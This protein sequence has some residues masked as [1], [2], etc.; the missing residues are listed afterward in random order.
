MVRPIR[1]H[2]RDEVVLPLN[3]NMGLVIPTPIK[4]GTSREKKFI[5]IV[6]TQVTLPKDLH[7]VAHIP[8][9]VERVAPL[10]WLWLLKDPEAST[11][12]DKPMV[13][14]RLVTE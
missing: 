14:L 11:R 9:E 6:P 5:L 2:A 12:R 13:G 8:A 3:S 1:V 7:I 10:R 4:R